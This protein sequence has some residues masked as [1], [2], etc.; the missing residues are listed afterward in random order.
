MIT[1]RHDPGLEE[2]ALA[3]G[4]T[5]FLRKP[6]AADALIDCLERALTT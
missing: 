5:C 1:A 2:R 3:S 4:V 6:V